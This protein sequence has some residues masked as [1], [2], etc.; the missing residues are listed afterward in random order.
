M[1]VPHGKQYDLESAK[2]NIFPEFS[3]SKTKR[4]REA[5]EGTEG[6]DVVQSL[7]AVPKELLRKRCV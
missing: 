2:T 1:A 4:T 6:S 7:G 5:R 3:R